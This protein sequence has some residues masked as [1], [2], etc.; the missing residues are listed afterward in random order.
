MTGAGLVI[1]VVD[2]VEM[3]VSLYTL[4][5]STEAFCKAGLFCILEQQESFIINFFNHCYCAICEKFVLAEIWAF[6]FKKEKKK[7]CSVYF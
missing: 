6:L 2:T 4:Y 1:L 5:F 7:T 3:W